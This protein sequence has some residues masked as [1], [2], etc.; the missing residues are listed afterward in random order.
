MSNES[1]HLN[2]LL[3]VG[4][5]VEAEAILRS[6]LAKQP[7]DGVLHL[8]LSRVLCRL[9]R[10]K[11]AEDAAR[12]AIGLLPDSGMPHE[13]LAESL[14]NSSK[15]KEA[16]IAISQA[17]ELDGHDADRRAILARIYLERDRYETSLEHANE[18]LAIDPD[19]DGCRFY[20]TIALGKLGFH[21]E[22]DET[23][24]ALLS[25]DPDDSTNHSAR[26]W[27]LLERNAI[28]EARMHFQEALRLDPDNEDARI[29][30]ARTLQ[31]GNPLL[32]WLLRLIIAL[33]RISITKVIV[34]GILFGVVL[35]NFLKGKGQPEI[36]R[37]MGLIISTTFMLFFYLALVVRPL[38]DVL[39]ALSR[40]GREALGPYEMR[41][42]R[43]SSLPLL[44][45][46]IYLGI[47]L[48][49]GGKPMPVAAVGWLASA[50]LLYES[51]SNRH[52]WVRRRMWWIAGVACAAAIWLSAGPPLILRP[53]ALGVISQLVQAKE[54]AVK[55]DAIKQLTTRL[56]ELMRMRKYAFDFPALLIYLI[57]VYSDEIAGALRRRAPDEKD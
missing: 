10:P 25:A 40:K 41:A 30:L 13:F 16:E 20:R 6:L 55:K 57:A 46:L 21:E 29:G 54:K 3:Q 4:R 12:R 49:G 56:E 11:E 15:L 45:G 39:L 33:S 51:A 52:P 42:V 28:P 53:L 24:L 8:Q 27:I 43:W 23:A 34:F 1:A 2:I 18:G 32:G 50:T 48:L 9:D 31:Q 38:F 5:Y 19:H 44:A 36:V 26:G 47:W 17:V 22:A 37:T 35:P 7:D 14:I